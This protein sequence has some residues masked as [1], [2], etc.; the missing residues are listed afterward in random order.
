M[1]SLNVATSVCHA[2]TQTGD[3][4]IDESG[5]KVFEMLGDVH[6]PR[7][8]KDYNH[9]KIS[10]TIQKSFVEKSQ[11]GIL[12]VLEHTKIPG[13]FKI[14]QSKFPKDVRHNQNCY[15][16]ETSD[17]HAT[18][19]PFIGYAQAEKLALKILRHKRL[20]IV[21]CIRCTK[22]HQ[23]WFL[24]TREEVVN[25]VE[26]AERWFKMP[27]YELQ[28]GVYKLTPEANDIH[29]KLYRFSVSKW[30][31]LMDE[32][33]GSNDASRALPDAASTAAARESG[34]SAERAAERAIPR[35]VV[36]ESPDITLPPRY[37]M[38]AKSPAARSGVGRES[39]LLETEEI[40][41][42]HQRQSREPTPDG[43]GN[44]KLV[45][46]LEIKRTIRTKVSLSELSQGSGVYDFSKPV[47][48]GCNGEK[49]RGTEIKVQEVGK[50]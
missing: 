37:K 35:V 19:E 23:E 8:G 31:E 5:R 39:P 36:D 30:K 3:N 26:Q 40:F 47:V 18:G 10:Q 50:V 43:D 32:V 21:E 16:T 25:V 13:L 4:D 17:A 12:Y 45:T 41:A 11:A 38:R 15:K 48:F 24:A 29:K 44:Y 28:G 46:E 33:Y 34:A 49:E 2:S 9:G 20:L 14:G 42:M 1:R 22:T 27:A 7:E 6:F